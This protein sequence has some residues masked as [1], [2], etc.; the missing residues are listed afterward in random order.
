MTDSV[1][2]KPLIIADYL[3]DLWIRMIQRNGEAAELALIRLRKGD[4]GPSGYLQSIGDWIDGNLMDGVDLAETMVAGPGF[5]VADS[6]VRSNPYAI[7]PPNDCAYRV[8]VTTPLTRGFGDEL[9][10]KAVSFE[11]VKGDDRTHC[12]TGLLVSGAEKF[13][14][15]VNRTNL[16]SGSYAGEVLVT[17]TATGM[18]DKDDTK[19]QNVTIEL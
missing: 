3:S 13:H 11:S 7:G 1:S 15:L 8:K 2:S 9:P 5:K 17:P 10:A 16:Q 4:F 6:V 14:I 19:P 12:P 18:A